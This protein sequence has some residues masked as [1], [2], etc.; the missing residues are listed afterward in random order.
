MSVEFDDLQPNR[1]IIR[2]NKKAALEPVNAALKGKPHIF[3]SWSE[4]IL[5]ILVSESIDLTSYLLNF[6]LS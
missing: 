6:K 4:L 3:E 1:M 2:A 5:V